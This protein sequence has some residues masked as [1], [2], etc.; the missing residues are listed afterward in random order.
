[1]GR[2]KLEDARNQFSKLARAACRQTQVVTSP[3]I[4]SM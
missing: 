1:M 3:P 2:W 4:G